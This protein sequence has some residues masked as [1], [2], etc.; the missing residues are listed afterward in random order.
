MA[1]SP[2]TAMLKKFMLRVV[3][4]HHTKGTSSIAGVGPKGE[5]TLPSTLIQSW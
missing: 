1:F 3:P 4:H 2:A 5:C